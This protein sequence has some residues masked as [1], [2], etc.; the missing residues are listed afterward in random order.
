M[1]DWYDIGCPISSNFICTSLAFF[2]QPVITCLLMY[3]RVDFA[4]MLGLSPLLR[5]LLCIHLFAYLLTVFLCTPTRFP[6]TVGSIL[7]SNSAWILFW[8]SDGS[9]LDISNDEWTLV[10]Y[11]A[12]GK[13]RKEKKRKT[14]A[15][16]FI[17]GS[18][19]WLG[20]PQTNLNLPERSQSGYMIS[21]AFSF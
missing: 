9:I 21:N 1:A 8:V 5:I 17:L 4:T 10:M 13:S 20:T 12:F 6:M 16:K 14:I 2:K 19:V 11:D 3:R 18:P 15:K 7:F